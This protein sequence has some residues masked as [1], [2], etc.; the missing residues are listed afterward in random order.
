MRSSQTYL[1]KGD[2]SKQNELEKLEPAPP[3]K[4]KKV[5][6]FKESKMNP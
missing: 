6:P 5:Y 3:A 2:A 4:K 1:R